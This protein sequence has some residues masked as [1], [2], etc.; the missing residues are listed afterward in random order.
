MKHGSVRDHSSNVFPPVSW[1]I[2]MIWFY[3]SHVH[4]SCHLYIPHRTA[5]LTITLWSDRYYHVVRTSVSLQQSLHTSPRAL[6]SSL[7]ADPAINPVMSNGGASRCPAETVTSLI[8]LLTLYTTF[9]DPGLSH[10]LCTLSHYL[11]FFSQLL[12]TVLPCD[13]AHDPVDDVQLNSLVDSQV[14]LTFHVCV[15]N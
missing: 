4:C 11:C 9:S 13:S 2:I 10:K 5:P 7:S 15:L 6:L 12:S 1:T 8:L 14:P 3:R